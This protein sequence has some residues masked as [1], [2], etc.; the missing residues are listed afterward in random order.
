MEH[1]GTIHT[2][3]PVLP[4]D[5]TPVMTDNP[6]SIVL[7][8]L[9]I[10]IVTFLLLVAECIGKQRC[11][12]RFFKSLAAFVLITFIAVQ[13]ILIWHTFQ[14]I[15]CEA[16]VESVSDWGIVVVLVNAVGLMLIVYVLML[17]LHRH[18]RCTRLPTIVLLLLAGSA[19]FVDWCL[20][21]GIVTSKGSH[22][23][24]AIQHTYAIQAVASFVFV[25]CCHGV[26][27]VT[28]PGTRQVRSPSR[29]RTSGSLSP[30]DALARRA[31]SDEGALPC[32]GR[33]RSWMAV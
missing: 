18:T 30:I 28:A 16:I 3:F 7:Q 21:G 2:L 32:D 1:C 20:R 26:R 27:F 5:P 15:E 31:G 10:M 9:P 17:S 22:L 8:G 12:T 29:S 33:D 25:D 6:A 23:L 24:A 4:P 14:I 19:L 13:S 11:S